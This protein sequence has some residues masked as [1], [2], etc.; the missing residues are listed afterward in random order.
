MKINLILVLL[1]VFFSSVYANNKSKILDGYYRKGE[2][3][4][5]KK[6]LDTLKVSTKEDIAGKLF[7]YDLLSNSNQ[8]YSILSNK[9][10]E[11]K[12]GQ[13]AILMQGKRYFLQRDYDRA[14][15]SFSKLNKSYKSLQNYWLALSYFKNE[16]WRKA[17]IKAQRYISFSDKSYKKDKCYL[18]IAISYQNLKFYDK[19]IHTFKFIRNNVF[20]IHFIPEII[21]RLGI[22]LERKGDS[23]DALEEYSKII[24]NYSYSPF[25]IK[26]ENRLSKKDKMKILK[27][28]ALIS[29]IL[30]DEKKSLAKIKPDAKQHNYFVKGKY[31]IQAGAYSSKK[32]AEIQKNRILK[33]GLKPFIKLKKYGNKELLT[34]SLGPFNSKKKA[35][36]TNTKLK[37]KKIKAYIYRL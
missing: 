26:T 35:V 30:K 25:F 17:I 4:N 14:I 11:T 16:E 33:L 12:F 13:Q 28:S 34:V 36:E 8:N 18:I 29:P 21:Y 3:L 37:N 19:A 31:Y 27:N 20:D 5:L 6:C 1:I 15:K 2:I 9:Y 7:Y 22:C 24:N 23:A 32:Y 10:P